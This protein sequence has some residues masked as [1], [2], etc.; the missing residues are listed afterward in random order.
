[1]VQGDRHPVIGGSADGDPEDEGD[2]ELSA[3]EDAVMS[4]SVRKTIS[5]RHSV[6]LP[7]SDS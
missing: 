2:V 3:D 5:G 4:S 6:F 1:M 7:A